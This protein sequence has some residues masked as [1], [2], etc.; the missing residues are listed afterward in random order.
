[1]KK[2][3]G[4]IGDPIEHSLSPV[5]HNAAFEKLGLDAVY[6][7][8]G[9]AQ[10]ELGDAI[11][12]AKSLGIAGLNVTIPLKEKALSFVNAEVVAKKIGAINTID[13]SI[14][15][16]YNTDGIGSLRVLKETVG[17]LKGKNVL[18]LGA[19]GAAKA[20]SYYLDTEGA[21][22]TI[23]NRTKERAAQLASNLRNANSIG[24]DAELKEHVKDSDILINATSVG[25]HP[26]ED[27]TLVNADM[28]HPD[29]VVFDIVYNPV[30]TKLLREAKKAGVKKVVDGVKMLVYQ[31]AASFRIWTK[32]EPPV[33][34]MEKAVRDALIRIRN[35][36]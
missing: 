22:V 36:F 3:Y 15:V 10:E 25:M 32:M 4:I 35:H 14:G 29:L 24:L 28:M 11:K 18:I 21:R 13:F 5:M 2:I 30:D 34:V 20:I 19:G 6:L 27:A 31:G 26:H 33:E 7:A 12:G 1:M 23:A 16:G 17:E 8:F 9:V